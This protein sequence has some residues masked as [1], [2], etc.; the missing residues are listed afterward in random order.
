MGS[1]LIK[2]A[3]ISHRRGRPELIAASIVPLPPGTLVDGDIM[4][5]AGI[6]SA[7]QKA[8]SSLEVSGA[9]VSTCVGGR[10]VIVKRIQTESVPSHQVD[11]L[12]RMEA[13]QH[14]PDISA[15]EVD[16]HLFE[17]GE[18]DS[19]VTALLVA[20]KKDLIG[21]RMRVMADAGVKPSILDVESFALRNA[22]MVN[23]PSSMSGGV[24]LLNI[25]HETTSV[26]ILD[27]GVPAVT[28]DID[29][30]VRHLKE[31]LQRNHGIGSDAASTIL[32]SGNN[33]PELA[34]CVLHRAE[35]IALMVERAGTFLGTYGRSST[36]IASVYICGGGAHTV[37]LSE[38]LGQRLSARVHMANSVN[39]IAVKKGAFRDK[40]VDH[41]S[42][43]FM[44][45][46]GLALRGID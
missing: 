38:Q 5:P 46:I 19:E 18:F 28:R 42:P 23:H 21:A 11:E 33:P 9:R 40:P 44:V 39:N 3:A 7:I 34:E 16:F 12:M 6:A 4:D 43:I 25:G 2:A 24:A 22:F 1:G 20:A 8:V 31:D 15:V 36:E 45:A 10:D 29:F 32:L 37:G 35:E 30:G 14:V 41:L 26:S 27:D 17:K 13:E